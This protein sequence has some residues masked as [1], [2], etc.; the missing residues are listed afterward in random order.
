VRHYNSCNKE[1]F[2]ISSE[3]KSRGFIKACIEVCNSGYSALK[4]S[5]KNNDIVHNKKPT[6]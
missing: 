1:S 3:K 5:A 6:L 4:A 2:K